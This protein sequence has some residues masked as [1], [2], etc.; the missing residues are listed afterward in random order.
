LPVQLYA[1]ESIRCMHKVMPH[2]KST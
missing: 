1:L 2:V